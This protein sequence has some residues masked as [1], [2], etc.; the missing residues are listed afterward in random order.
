MWIRRWTGRF[1]RTTLWPVVDNETGEVIA[2]PLEGN[3]EGILYAE[4]DLEET[5]RGRIVQD[6]GGHYNRA[7]VFRLQ[8]G[9][10]ASR[11]EARDGAERIRDALQLVPVIVERK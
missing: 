6:F 8:A 4:A 3:Q 7:D 1:I 2:G 11:E 9:P 10:Y 5:L